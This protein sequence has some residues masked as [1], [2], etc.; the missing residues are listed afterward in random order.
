MAHITLAGVLLDPTGEFSVGD[1]VRFTHQS[2][3]GNTIKSAVS[4]LK[5]PPNGG[6]SVNLEYGLVLVEYNDYRLG[7]YRKLGVATVNATNTAT[8]IPELLNALV[9]VSSAEL[10]QFQTIQSNCV[11][12]QNAATASA[13]AALVS[14]NAAA[15]SAATLDLINDLS[16]AWIFDTVGGALGYKQSTIVFPIGKTIHLNDR[17]ADFNV[18]AGTG[19]ANTFNIIASTSVNQSIDLLKNEYGSFTPKQCGAIGDGVT[20]DTAVF[21]I[22]ESLFSS[23]SIAVGEF[24]LSNITIERELR[25]SRGGSIKSRTADVLISGQ[26]IAGDYKIFDTGQDFY[27]SLPA[28]F[29]VDPFIRCTGQE[30][31][32][33]DWFGNGRVQDKDLIKSVPNAT[34]FIGQAFRAATGKYIAFGANTFIGETTNQ[35]VG[36]AT[37]S[38]NLEEMVRWS[39]VD[40]GNTYKTSGTGIIGNGIAS[41]FLVASELKFNFGQ[42]VVQITNFTGQVNQFKDFKVEVFAPQEGANRFLGEFAAVLWFSSGDS[43]QIN[44]VWAA[45]SQVGVDNAE[46][47]LRNGVG[48][49]F[50]SVVD[51]QG[52]NVF[53][54]NNLYNYGVY[55]AI[56]SISN[57]VSFGSKEAAVIFG[58]PAENFTYPQGFANSMLNMTNGDLHNCRNDCILSIEAGGNPHMSGF[59]ANGTAEGGGVALGRYFA[60]CINSGALKGEISGFNIND[61]T[62]GILKATGSASFGN[63]TDIFDM[64]SGQ[65]AGLTTTTTTNRPGVISTSQSTILNHHINFGNI[66]INICNPQII[67]GSGNVHIHDISLHSFRGMSDSGLDRQLFQWRGGSLRIQDISRV[68]NNTQQ[69]AQYGYNATGNAKVDILTSEMENTTRQVGGSGATTMP[70]IVP[71]V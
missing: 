56:V 69:I 13:A 40:S 25:F 64:R 20:D 71:F 16:Q 49:Q 41:S 54:E 62:T 33:V 47:F 7:Q 6:Y 68:D 26:I 52:S 5:V 51:V 43:M 67:E 17:G 18:I 23:Y 60:S 61:F 39:I 19:T 53:S 30:R 63:D 32:M 38:Y 12:A 4:V 37:G 66:A 21:V 57:M 59:R 65:I 34:K 35:N 46:G 15:A 45:G 14:Q 9:P 2:T 42:P 24:L 31:V 27:A 29:I 10:I 1:K 48:I 55:S 58:L 28:S 44:N 50:Y 11:A 70:D 8:S 3:T 36:L 22:L